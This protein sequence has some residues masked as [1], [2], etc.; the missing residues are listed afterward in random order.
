M[1]VSIAVKGA[2]FCVTC[3]IYKCLLSKSANNILILLLVAD[4][5]LL[6]LLGGHGQTW[7]DSNVLK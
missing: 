5:Q 2:M 1:I 6:E 4:S 7:S 3:L